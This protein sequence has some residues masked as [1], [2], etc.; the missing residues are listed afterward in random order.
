MSTPRSGNVPPWPKIKVVAYGRDRKS[1]Y[2]GRAVK[3]PPSEFACEDGLRLAVRFEIAR[4][5]VAFYR[6]VQRGTLP[7]RFMV[8]VNGEPLTN[9]P[10]GLK[11]IMEALR[12]T[13]ASVM[14][15]T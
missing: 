4:C 2:Q 10:C 13:D 12:P 6:S 1:T 8:T 3:V 15:T 5:R 9:H 11:R 7:E 14:V